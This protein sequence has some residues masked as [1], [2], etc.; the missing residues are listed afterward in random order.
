LYT[1]VGFVGIGEA[2]LDHGTGVRMAL[3]TGA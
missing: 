1:R 3:E 2:V